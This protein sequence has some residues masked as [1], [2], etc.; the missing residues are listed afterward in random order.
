MVKSAELLQTMKT[1]YFDL[2]DTLYFRRDAF[3]VAFDEF[4]KNKD[5]K[6]K[7]LAHTR[8]Q[9]RSDEVFYKCQSGEISTEQ[10]YIYRFQAGFRDVGIEITEKQALEFYGLYKKALYELK[11]TPEVISMLDFAKSHFE[12]LGIMTNGES[13]HQRNKI[14]SL[15]LEKWISPDLIVIS[16]EHGCPK[17]DKRLFEIAKEKSGCTCENLVI[18]GDSLKNDILPAHELGWRSIW[19]NLYNERLCAPDFEVKDV[20]EI[21]GALEKLAGLSHI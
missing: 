7:S 17:P 4:F 6:L 14:K 13:I 2:D 1:I 15:G 5:E 16:G 9:I 19:I 12:K 18:V 21:P 3:F 10:M 11:L 20:S 8:Q